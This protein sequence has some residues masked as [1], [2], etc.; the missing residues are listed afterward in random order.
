MHEY[1][2]HTQANKQL[3]VHMHPMICPWYVKK[4]ES[5]NIMCIPSFRLKDNSVHFHECSPFWVGI[6]TMCIIVN[7]WNC[8]VFFIVNGIFPCLHNIR[9]AS[10]IFQSNI[11]ILFSWATFSCHGR[12][13][14]LSICN[15]MSWYL[16]KF[17]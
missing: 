2:T 7:A 5:F 14:P 1:N 15:F 16:R 3:F 9:N 12:H 11:C 17:V 4:H 8:V 6:S 13:C 10:V